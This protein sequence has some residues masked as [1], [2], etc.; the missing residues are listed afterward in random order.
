[1]NFP[2]LFGQEPEYNLL[3]RKFQDK[4]FQIL[5]NFSIVSNQQGP[6]EE[7][8]PHPLFQKSQVYSIT[9]QVDLSAPL[10]HLSQIGLLWNT[11]LL[12]SR[13]HNP[14]SKQANKQYYFLTI[15]IS[16]IL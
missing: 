1:M 11:I 13:R 6:E 3:Q 14:I 15:F 7:R 2:L 8:N 5:T 4:T 12:V 16:K 10:E 9:L